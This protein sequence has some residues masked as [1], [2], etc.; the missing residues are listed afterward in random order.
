MFLSEPPA[1]ERL[2]IIHHRVNPHREEYEEELETALESRCRFDD[3][4]LRY[5]NDFI[6][7]V[8][9]YN[10]QKKRCKLGGKMKE[11]N[12]VTMKETQM[13][14]RKRRGT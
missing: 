6:K 9:G 2:Y 7:G 1:Q 13:K 11:E 8:R 3:F 10:K 4:V 12:E 5:W 14:G